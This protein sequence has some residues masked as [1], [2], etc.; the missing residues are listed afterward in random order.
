MIDYGQFVAVI[1]VLGLLGAALFALSSRGLVSFRGRTQSAGTARQMKSIERLV[2]TAN[3][4]LHL[5][6]VGDRKV[7]VAVS[8]NGCSLLE[9]ADRHSAVE[10]STGV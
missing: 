1:A 10:R 2:L 3:H 8:P 7:L 9:G 5:I 4:S 6:Q